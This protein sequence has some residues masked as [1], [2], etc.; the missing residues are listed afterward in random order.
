MFNKMKKV[1]A[2]TATNAAL[3]ANEWGQELMVRLTEQRF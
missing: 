2:Q 1:L 3:E